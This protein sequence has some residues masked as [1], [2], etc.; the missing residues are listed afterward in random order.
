MGKQKH[1]SNGT[2]I[3][4]KIKKTIRDKTRIIIDIDHQFTDDVEFN[5]DIKAKPFKM[6]E[7]GIG[8]TGENDF[9]IK[10]AATK[11]F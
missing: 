1:E 2:K 7:N 11:K 9:K 6:L 8:V 10:F 3:L 5:I 4:S